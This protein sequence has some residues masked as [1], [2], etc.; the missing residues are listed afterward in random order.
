MKITYVDRSGRGTVVIEVNGVAVDVEPGV[1][2]EVPGSVAGHP[3]SPRLAEI[4]DVEL[5]AAAAARDHELT[6]AL[7]A[8]LVGVDWGEGLLAQPDNWQ[9][10]AKTAK[11]ANPSPVEV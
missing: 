2:I 5:P 6:R 8:E 4:L 10:V 9:P 1:T 7:K 3:P 11:P